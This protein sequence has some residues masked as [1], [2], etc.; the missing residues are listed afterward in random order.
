M[1]RKS[2]RAE[3]LFRNTGLE[4]PADV[5]ITGIS[6]DS[7]RV[8]KGYLFICH[9]GNRADGHRFAA[10][11]L[12]NGAAL[13]VGEH[14]VDGVPNMILT[15]SSRHTES[16]L[17]YNFTSRPTDCMTKIAVTGTAGKTSVAFILRHILAACG[18]K[19]GLISTVGVYAGEI[20]L[21]TGE[22]GGSSVS[23]ISGAMTTPD[24]E[25]FFGAAAEMRAAGC[26]TLVFEASSQA[27][28]MGR[29]AAV[30]PDRVIYT[31]L[32]SEHLDY[33]KTMENYFAAK[34][35]LMESADF[36]IINADDF[37]IAR[38][39]GMYPDKN[40]IRCTA[41]AENVSQSEVA[42][43]KYTSHGADGIEYLYYSAGAVFRIRSPLLGKYSVY[44]TM[45]AAACAI[46]LGAD[47]MTVKAALSDFHGADGRLTRVRFP[48]LKRESE[49]G[50]LP[51]V[52]IDYAHTPDALSAVL[53]AVRELSDG[54]V[55]AVFGCGGERDRT[56]RPMMA[57]AALSIADHTVITGDNSRGE[58]PEQI[59][60]DILT[61]A[62]AG[63]SFTVIPDRREAIKY[64]V[65]IAGAGDMILLA[66]KGHEKYEIDSSGKHP[67]DEEE[68]AQSAMYRKFRKNGS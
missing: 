55:I 31:N 15:Q 62:D 51:D 40:I 22:S 11:A 45:E 28:A 47:P 50:L 41:D 23:D 3:E 34:A 35:S 7:R 68:L 54:R 14:R 60:S 10:E 36:A 53:T 4:A 42:A 65:N 66:G 38:L 27:I 49:M 63:G 67:F 1:R 20:K 43:L 12:A 25:Y 37:M 13:V 26:D 30:R 6:C 29:L 5:E 46:S 48:L 64:A 16:L 58:D 52:F 32:S 33:H 24:P 19:V 39:H 8:K 44:N 2:M 56:K 61:G 9:S 18:R 59:I 21:D 17:W 57:R